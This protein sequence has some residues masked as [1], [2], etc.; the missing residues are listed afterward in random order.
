MAGFVATDV[1]LEFLRAGYK[2]RGTFRSQSKADDWVKLHGHEGLFESTI[3]EDIIAPNALDKA[4]EGV[5]LCLHTASPV[6]IAPIPMD[7]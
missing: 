6:R 7:R 1:A 4:M 2:V 5:T 3:V